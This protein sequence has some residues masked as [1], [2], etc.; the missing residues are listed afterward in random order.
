MSGQYA[1]STRAFAITGRT[2]AARL[3]TG[4][5]SI[6]ESLAAGDVTGSS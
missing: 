4:A 6:A 5:S 1:I 2:R 3:D